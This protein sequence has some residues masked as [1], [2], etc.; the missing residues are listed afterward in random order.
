MSSWDTNLRGNICD[1]YWELICHNKLHPRTSKIS[2]PTEIAVGTHFHAQQGTKTTLVFLPANGEI[3]WTLLPNLVWHSATRKQLFLYTQVTDQLWENQKRISISNYH[4]Q[5]QHS[6]LSLKWS[7]N[8]IRLSFNQPNTRTA[9][10]LVDVVK[11][12]SHR[13]FCCDTITRRVA[14]QC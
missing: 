7:S 6:Y 3:S 11:H 10:R 8:K 4:G 14:N 13:L 12:L 5:H 9:A 2:K 1:P